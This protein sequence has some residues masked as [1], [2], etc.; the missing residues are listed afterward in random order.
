VRT[1]WNV[2]LGVV[3]A[4]KWGANHVA[5]ASSIGA[6]R[7]IC[8]ADATLLGELWQKYPE[9]AATTNFADLLQMPL[10]GVVIATP[11][12]THA[13]FAIQ[14][15]EA[16]KHVLVEKPLALTVEDAQAILAA[17]RLH[18]V[19]VFVGHLVLYQQCVRAVLDHVRAGSI[20]E[21][22]HVRA[23]RASFGRLRF[24]EDV[25]WS[26][27]PHD[28][29]ITLAIF[30]EEPSDGTV[31]RHSY[32]TPGIAD[33]AYADFRFSH[34]GTAH[35]EV[36]WLDPNKGSSLDVF[37]SE[38]TLS[39]RELR[40]DATL[41]ITPCGVRDGGNGRMEL[42]RGNET[43]T[44]FSSDEPLRTELQSFIAMIAES[45]PVITDGEAGLSVVR[46]LSMAS[47]PTSNIVHE[48]LE[49]TP[50]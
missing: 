23:R 29:S 4:G 30:G 10:D 36:T 19:H 12:P 32:A 48:I 27:A 25:W 46:A 13:Q 15:I 37:G 33:F 11:A 8:D 22:R 1:P 35:I 16:G 21:V 47:L 18:G 5:T 24:V 28:V 31:V 9:V 38:G 49:R 6:L 39:L 45:V 43:T 50:A 3:G 42:W 20:G 26:F 41:T 2:S 14:A 34:G 7:A 44:R 17:A 40:S